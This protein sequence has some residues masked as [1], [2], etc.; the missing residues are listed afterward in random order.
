LAQ[1]TTAAAVTAAPT[2]VE[3]INA[4]VKPLVDSAAGALESAGSKA[5][6]ILG[7]VAEGAAVPL[8][9]IL[10][11]VKTGGPGDMPDPNAKMCCTPDGKY[12]TDAQASAEHNK[13]ARPSTEEKHQEG[14]ARRSRDR[15][16]EKGDARRRP[17]RKPPNGWKGPWPPKDGQNW[18]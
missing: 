15:G 7:D 17:P 9:I 8:M 18:N 16:G 12:L 10:N 13:G 5:L 2:T 1:N 3:E 14:Q 6:S 4:V 11:P